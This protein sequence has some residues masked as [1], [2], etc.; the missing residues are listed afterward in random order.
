V[1]IDP[2]EDRIVAKGIR[3]QSV[4]FMENARYLWVKRND[5]WKRKHK[6]S[7][8]NLD[9]WYKAKNAVDQLAPNCCFKMKGFTF[10]Y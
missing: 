4:R 8:R 3:E 9:E 10:Q 6:F 7:V 2:N 1:A 5:V